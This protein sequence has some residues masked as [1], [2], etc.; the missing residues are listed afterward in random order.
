MKSYDLLDDCI[1]NQTNQD[2]IFKNEISN[3]PFILSNI[4]DIKKYYSKHKCNIYQYVNYNKKLRVFFNIILNNN[5][6]DFEEILNYN[7]KLLKF[8]LNDLIIY[9]ET[10]YKFTIIHKYYY[11][12][13][14]NEL[15]MYLVK[16]NLINIKIETNNFL[17]TLF[18]DNIITYSNY[19]FEDTLINNIDTLL[20][21]EDNNNIKT[22]EKYDRYVGDINFDINDTVFIKSNMGSGK[23]TSV[24]NYIKMTK[25]DSFLLISCRKTLTYSIYEKLE[26]NKIYVDNYLKLNKEKIKL[27]NKLIISPDSIHKIDFPLK[28]YDLIWIDEG[29]SFM[30]YLGNYL[31]LSENLNKDTIII[32]EWL[33]QNCK[34]LLITDADLDINI[35]NYYLCYRKIQSSILINYNNF[36]DKNEYILFDNKNEIN[37]KL[38]SDLINQN[39]IYI[40]SDSLKTT[41]EIYKYICDLNIIDVNKILLYNSESDKIYEKKMYTVNKFWSEYMVVIVSPR[42]I[43]GIDFIKEH[44]DYIYG[45]YNSRTLSAREAIQQIGRIRNL[46]KKQVNIFMENNVKKSV[47]NSIINIKYDLA[48]Y[49]INNIFYKK[50][51]DDIEKL[52]N[53]LEFKINQLGFKYIDMSNSINYLILYSLYEK[54]FNLKNF[55][56]IFKKNITLK[57]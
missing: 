38:K 46:K 47:E 57:N 27:S 36:I 21:L 37:V 42:I 11:M 35:I 4:K 9:Q 2:F 18:N 29:C 53:T 32:I 1:I 54:N 6:D 13:D 8:N 7:I 17:N 12:N 44:F 56:E 28:K 3:K 48:N 22:I 24:V 34:R 25:P 16:L 15:S 39:N 43:M 5:K 23:S 20:K 31:I 19:I 33:L 10:D 40:C 51:T 26:S 52:F 14:I 41:K 45:F 55:I 49:I 50:S 30:N